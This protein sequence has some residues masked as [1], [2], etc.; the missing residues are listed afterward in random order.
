MKLRTLN[1]P[2][3][4]G[5][6]HGAAGRSSETSRGSGVR[7]SSF[8]RFR[9]TFVE[10]LYSVPSISALGLGHPKPQDDCACPR[11]I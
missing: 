8:S 4:L 6:A 3:Y 10:G 1:C 2:H 11:R 9:D 7:G 5:D